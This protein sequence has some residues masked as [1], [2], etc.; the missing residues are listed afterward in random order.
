VIDR[1]PLP[2]FC[3][4]LDSPKPEPVTICEHLWR[5]SGILAI[6]SDSKVRGKASG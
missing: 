5:R 3:G 6:S 2:G 4:T 1:G